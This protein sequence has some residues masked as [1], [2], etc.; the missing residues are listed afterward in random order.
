MVTKE[1]LLRFRSFWVFPLL[2]VALLLIPA[3]RPHSALDLIGWII[4]GAAMWTLLEYGFHR[5]LLHA[6][7]RS[8]I[9][10]E[11]VNTSHFQHHHAPRDRDLI[12]VQL[13][14]ALVTSAV[15][16]GVL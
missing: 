12:L 9:L 13:P 11:F 10:R 4:V 5:F 8:P 7:F 1:R 15:I 16:Y 6:E 3:T 2:S 14:F